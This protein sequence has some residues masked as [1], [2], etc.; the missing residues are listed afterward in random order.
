MKRKKDTKDLLSDIVV[1]NKYAKHIPEL[2]RRETWSEI[3]DRYIAMMMKKYP[4]LK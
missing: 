3:V 1:Y 2:K 4:H